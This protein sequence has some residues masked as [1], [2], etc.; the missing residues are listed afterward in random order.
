[1]RRFWGAV[2]MTKE[3]IRDLCSMRDILERYGIPKPNRAAFICCPFHKE[4]TPSMKIYKD[5]YH[6]FGC[7]ANG[8]IFS[9][10]QAM[11]NVDFKTAFK[12]LGGTYVEKSDFQRKLFQYRCQKR[13]ET[14]KLREAKRKE[15]HAEVLEEIRLMKAIK[16]LSPVFSDDWCYAVD[17][18]EY[19]FYLLEYLMTG[20]R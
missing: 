17:K 13:K 14:E 1:M 15:L 12:M 5:S 9:F 4:K 19:D 20:K 7:G 2:D 8:D 3:E 10:V 18:L 16:V 6:C 11:E